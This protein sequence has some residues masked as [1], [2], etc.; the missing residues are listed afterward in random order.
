MVQRNTWNSALGEKKRCCFLNIEALRSLSEPHS[1]VPGRKQQLWGG[2]RWHE[3]RGGCCPWVTSIWRQSCTGE[4][5]TWLWAP[6][7]SQ[8]ET[9]GSPQKLLVPMNSSTRITTTSTTVLSSLCF[10]PFRSLDET[11]W[12]WHQVKLTTALTWQLLSS[13]F[14]VFPNSGLI[15]L[16]LKELRRILMTTQGVWSRWKKGLQLNSGKW[17]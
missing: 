4:L 2:G 7:E 17:L 12:Y 15:Y 10:F 5:L 3:V 14:L 8:A 9:K 16:H 13:V 11:N 6:G 1:Y